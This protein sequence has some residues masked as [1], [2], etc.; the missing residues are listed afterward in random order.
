[1]HPDGGAGKDK[2]CYTLLRLLQVPDGGHR[3]E[4]RA[5]AV[6]E[7]HDRGVGSKPLVLQKV[8]EGGKVGGLNSGS[9]DQDLSGGRGFEGPVSKDGVNKPNVT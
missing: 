6:R 4:E 1:M 3:V 5:S 7:L 9:Y 8:V 2:G